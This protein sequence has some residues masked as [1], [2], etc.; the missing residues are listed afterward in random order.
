MGVSGLT[1]CGLLTQLSRLTDRL[2]RIPFPPSTDEYYFDH[3][4]NIH[5]ISKVEEQLNAN[6]HS[7]NLLRAQI[8]KE[9]QLLNQD[10][11][12][13]DYL[14]HSLRS[15]EM[16]RREQNKTFHPVARKLRQD[17]HVNLLAPDHGDTKTSEPPIAE[18]FEDAELNPILQQL[19][20]HLSSM[21]TNAVGLGGI[22]NAIREAAVELEVYAFSTPDE[23]ACRQAAGLVPANQ[24]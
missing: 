22:K 21:Q 15:N 19:Q 11:A 23:K 14:E 3:E 12:E 6:I 7:M 2:P 16:L 4:A 17:Q 5:R 13:V 8:A 10:Q 1:L 18:L 20:N 24:T 9:E